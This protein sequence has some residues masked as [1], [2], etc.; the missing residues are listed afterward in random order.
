MDFLTIFPYLGIIILV[1]FNA[2]WVT[3]RKIDIEE[4][5]HKDH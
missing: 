5:I 4:E 1:L 2:A 3:L